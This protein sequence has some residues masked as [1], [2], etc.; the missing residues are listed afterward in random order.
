MYGAVMMRR[1]IASN[2]ARLN[3]TIDRGN[4]RAIGDV[5]TLTFGRRSQVVITSAIPHSVRNH[6]TPKK[7]QPT[8]AE[9]QEDEEEEGI[10]EASQALDEKKGAHTEIGRLQRR[11]T[12][13]QAMGASVALAGKLRTGSVQIDEAQRGVCSWT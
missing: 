10:S 7:A 11:A 5:T 8:P 9:E 6:T 13:A 12:Q 1:W 2:Q 4:A 3:V